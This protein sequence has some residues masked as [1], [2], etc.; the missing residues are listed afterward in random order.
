MHHDNAVAVAQRVLHIVRD[1]HGSQALFSDDALGQRQH[2]L[3]G[4]GIKRRGMLI[5]Q[6]QV[7]TGQ[8]CHQQSQRLT[9]AARK[10]TNTGAQAVFKAQTQ[11]LEQPSVFI[12]VLAADGRSQRAGLAALHGDGHVLLNGH[13]CCSAH[14]RILEHAADVAG[15]LVLG[16]GVH[17]NA[18]DIDH[19][20]FRLMDAGNHVQQSGLA[21]AVA[22]DNRNKVAGI[23]R[24]LHAVQR[25]LLV[26]RAD[27]EGLLNSVYAQRTVFGRLSGEYR[28]F[29][30]LFHILRR[31][32]L[33]SHRL[34]GLLPAK[35]HRQRIEL[36]GQYR[37]RKRNGNDD[38][39]EQL[40]VLCRPVSLQ[41]D[42]LDNTVDD[43]TGGN[44]HQLAQQRALTEQHIAD[45][46]R[47][48]T[49]HDTAGT[50]VQR[51][52]FVVLRDQRAGHGDQT[53]GQHQAGE[54]G[55]VSVDA[56]RAAHML[57]IAG[58]ADNDALFRA[59]EPP[60]RQNHQHN[61]YS[62]VHQNDALLVQTKGRNN[63]ENC[64]IYLASL[65]NL[66][67]E[68]QI[69]LAHDVQ[70]N[71]VQADLRQNGRQQARN[72]QLGIHQTS[73]RAGSHARGK[74]HNRRREGIPSGDNQLSCHSA[75][76]RKASIN[77][78]ISK[79]QQAV[80]QKNAEGH[81][82]PEKAQRNGAGHRLP[83]TRDKRH[84]SIPLSS[85]II[86]P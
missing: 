68:G 24:Q 42:A 2:V 67:R 55:G 59:E 44:R 29:L 25:G 50:H 45:D 4:S 52:H 72:L 37:Q 47:S 18:A 38:R 21:R 80:G 69:R 64:G 27:V 26:D 13:A 15:A 70:I 73:H 12:A 81:Y 82:G 84:C 19:A 43:G 49:E 83:Q 51:C 32:F 79:I 60:Q 36:L 48:Q 3:G 61:S 7:R 74:C 62:A 9:L 77:R 65:G 85:I 58:G 66:H 40:E 31:C 17:M 8:R 41:N 71:R 35:A 33:R 39:G 22:A 86:F 53:V 56:Q 78:Q 11:R 76:Q 6:Q 16:Q 30:D 46:D 28:L 5:Q 1:H 57:V 14:H 34:D 75:A 10:Q 23:Q 54:L 20:C 63:A